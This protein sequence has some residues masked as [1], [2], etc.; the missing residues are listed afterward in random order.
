MLT[1]Q[2]TINFNMFG[3]LMEHW[4]YNNLY[5]TNVFSMQWSETPKKDT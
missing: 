5:D 3:A 4:I 1:N 2:V